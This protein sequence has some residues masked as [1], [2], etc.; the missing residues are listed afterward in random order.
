MRAA[1]A[2]RVRDIAAEF[3]RGFDALAAS[4][5]VTVFG[6]ARTPPSI[7]TTRSPRVGAASA[8]GFAVITGGGPG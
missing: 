8:A 1:D 4:A 2:E 3:A 7:P 6:S 5:A